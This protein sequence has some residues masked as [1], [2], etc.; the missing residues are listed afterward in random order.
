MSFNRRIVV[1]IILCLGV[2][3]AG[4]LG[5]VIIEDY[6]VPEGMYM[7]LITITTVGFGEVKPLSEAG[8]GFTALLIVFGLGSLAFATHALMES[9][10]EK[11]WSGKAGVRKMKKKISRL[12]SHYII[13]GFGRVGAA[14]LEYFDKKGIRSVMI[15]ANPA[16]CEVIKE[17]GYLHVEGD[18]TRESILMKAGIKSATGLLALLN[19]DPDNLFIVLGARELNP[20]LHIISRAEE[21]SSEK[22]ILRA[23]ADSVISP[24]ATAGKQIAGD[25]LAATGKV[26]GLTELS[27]RPD[28]MPQWITV[29]NGSS[30]LNETISAVSVR[31]GRDVMGLR[32][33][34]ND[35]ILPDPETRLEA[36]DMLLVV[37]EKQK[38][39]IK[40]EQR[41]PDPPKLVIADDNPV[42]LR[43]YTRLFQKAGFYPITTTNG[44]D[45]LDL[46]IRERPVAAVIDYMLPVMSGIE[47]CDQVRKIKACQETKLILFTADAKSDI[48]KR[49]LKSGADAVVVK[50]PEA[51]EVIET[52]IKTIRK[53]S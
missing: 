27:L 35:F 9:F 53:V 34:G 32:K 36:D 42:I 39:D 47:V 50:S 5:Y 41:S 10:L 37:D 49:A 7:S 12:K 17:K 29:H 20:T 6:T 51:S 45:G 28:A 30:M 21:A 2:L 40:P 8:R 24:F 52:V 16:Q 13:C 25:M 23:G 26:S 3:A 31:M 48:R 43:L 18:A 22:K 19:S 11:M 38:N 1:A 4:T 33:N 14:A 15:E 44:R 46:I